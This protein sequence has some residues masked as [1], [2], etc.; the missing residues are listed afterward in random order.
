MLKFFV[1]N[2]AKDANT[3]VALLLGAV[4]SV[5]EALIVDAVPQTELMSNLVAHDVASSHEQVLFPVRVFDTIPSRIIPSEREGCDSF[6]IT[7]PTK[8]EV[9]TRSWIKIFHRDELHGVGVSRT[10]FGQLI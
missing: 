10:I 5:H 1:A 3:S 7:G 9:P 8:A 6:G 4:D 2:G